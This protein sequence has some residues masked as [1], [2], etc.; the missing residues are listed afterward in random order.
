MG[1]APVLAFVI[2][3]HGFGHAA[4]QMEVIRA[5]LGRWPAARAVVLTA[6]PPA[7]F[8]DYLGA[9]PAILARVEVVPWRA[10]VGVVQRD[11]IVLDREATL[12]ALSEAWADPDRAERSLAAR[13]EPL[14]PALVLGDIPP[15]AFGAAA[16][17]GVPSLAIGNFDWAFIYGAYAREDPAFAPFA[18]LCLRWQALADA[19]VHLDPGPPLTGFTRV[20][21]AAPV[22]RGLLGDAARVRADWGSPPATAPCSRASA[23]SGSPAPAGASRRSPG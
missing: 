11:G 2:T 10:D 19:A 12:A 4:R 1:P 15:P 6:A 16:R 7:I 18:G 3:A 17:L 20:V 22:A 13:L 8:H 21:E 5:L 14:R 9:E 23:G